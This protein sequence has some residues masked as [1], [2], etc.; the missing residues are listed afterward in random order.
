MARVCPPPTPRDRTID[1]RGSRQI[2][3]ACATADADREYF[4][5]ARIFAASRP[6]LLLTSPPPFPLSL[7]PPRRDRTQR[8]TK[9]MQ[10]QNPTAV[11]IACTAVAQDDIT[12]D[13][14]PSTVLIIGEPEAGGR[15]QE[16]LHPR[17]R[18]LRRRQARR[19]E[20]LE[21]CKVPWG[22]SAPTA[23]KELL[24]ASR[25]RRCAPSSARTSRTRSPPSSPTRCA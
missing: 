14:T 17:R 11:M 10:I 15:H 5:A 13:G 19:H 4:T 24:T 12:G 7:P 20:F 25:R 3:R 1:R 6:S 16:G 9:E 23:D 2:W 22:R 18:G 21:T 8:S